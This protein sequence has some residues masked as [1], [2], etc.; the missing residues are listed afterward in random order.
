MPRLGKSKLV[1]VPQAVQPPCDGP[2]RR[3]AP[4]KQTQTQQNALKFRVLCESSPLGIFECDRQGQLTYHNR[5]MADLVG[6]SPGESLRD[7]WFHAIHPDDLPI[8]RDGW[9]R[10]LASGTQWRQDYRLQTRHQGTRWVRVLLTPTQSDASG[11]P[12]SFVGTVEDI[13]E[14]KMAEEVLRASHHELEAH[15]ARRTQELS[16]ANE[17]LLQEVADRK[18]AERERQEFASLVENSGDFIALADLNGH[19]LFLNE[20]G[21]KLVGLERDESLTGKTLADFLP[22]ESARHSREREFPAVKAE[23][24]W[25]GESQLRNVKTSKHVDVLVNSFLVG[26][27]ESHQPLCIATVQ[28]DITDR[29]RSEEAVRASE[30]RFRQ[31]ADNID[32]V[33]W[34]S[35][36]D[37]RKILYVS[38]AY[39]EIF[40]C[41]CESLY[42]DPNS[43]LNIVHPDDRQRIVE[44]LPKVR[45]GGYDE[46]FRIVRFDGSIRTIRSRG[47]PVRNEAGEVYRVAGI[48][49]D[50]TERKQVEEE[51]LAERRFLEH[52]LQVQEGE[53][54]LV[55][56]DI[57]DGFV[58]AVIAAVM[59]LEGLG[60]DP[61]VLPAAREKLEVPLNLL[62]DSIEEARRMISGLRPPII[63]EQGLV[64][65]IDY[66]INEQPSRPTKVTFHHAVK[67]DRL[68]GVLENT[69]FRI[70]QE[71]LTNVF[72]HSQSKTAQVNLIQ[73]ADRLRLT[74]EDWGIGFDPRKIK[75]RQFGLRGIRERARLFGGTAIIHSSP[76]LGTRIS[77]EL[78]LKLAFGVPRNP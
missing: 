59:H 11:R 52:L 32:E 64:A 58:Q 65:A 34:V 39:S 55:A 3:L 62:R 1:D 22:P 47:F 15:V 18:Q 71:A 46:I 69:L 66:L 77:V 30:H 48:A 51:L 35:E 44:S 8:L 6:M 50:I 17:L 75:G 28:R 43:Y 29:K 60:V 12:L 23:G 61:G 49:E 20:T 72:R 19:L 27:P 63:D 67:F 54:K 13:T 41:S 14:R 26:D 40:G 68:D 33:F 37:P 31:L 78:P 57:H 45:Q 53:R 74:V 42:Q 5:Q 9:E 7:V 16:V 24:R 21:R 38:P 73:S 76:G 4:R 70:V 25:M 56:Y 10:T 36:F 2:Q